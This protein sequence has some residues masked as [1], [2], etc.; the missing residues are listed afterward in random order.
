[1]NEFLPQFKTHTH[2]L[3]DHSPDENVFLFYY[4]DFHTLFPLPTSIPSLARNY[5]ADTEFFFL[6]FLTLTYF[7]L[8]T[9]GISFIYLLFH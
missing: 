4:N 5:S 3:F 8:K 9:R 1:M 7:L 6:T 2:K